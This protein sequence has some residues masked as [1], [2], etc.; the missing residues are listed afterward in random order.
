M[1]FYYF[2]D[3]E[4]IKQCKLNSEIIKKNNKLS[5]YNC[6]CAFDTETTS[7]IS[8]NEKCGTIYLWCFSID[9]IFFIGRTTEQFITFL[10]SV[11]EIFNISSQLKMIIYIHNLAF[12]FQFIKGYFDYSNII[13]N[14]IR[15]PI[16]VETTTGIE[17]RCSYLL[18]GYSLENL[19]KIKLHGI[20]KLKG[21]LNYDLKRNYKTRISKKEY[22]YIYNDVL[23]VSKYIQ[24][25]KSQNENKIFRI[26][27]TKTGYV[28]RFARVETIGTGSRKGF[29]MNNKNYI[30]RKEIKDLI[31]PD[32]NFYLQLK[33]AFQGGYTHC[34]CFNSGKTFKNVSSYD[35]T[36]SYPTML[37]CK[38]FP[39]SSPR[40][41]KDISEKQFN[42]CLEIYNCIFNIKFVNI[43]SKE[44]FEHYISSS[45]CFN[46]T[47]IKAE[48]GRLI[49]ADV[50]EM[51]ITEIDYKIIK[52]MYNFDEMYISN[53]NVFTKGYLPKSFI[54]SVLKLYN[55]KTEL[56]GV[57]GRE[58]EYLNSKEM[59][60]SMYGMCVTDI[61]QDDF[62]VINGEWKIDEKKEK[63][64]IIEKNNNSF[65]R[66]LY[67]PWGIYTTAYA[68][69]ALFTA[70]KTIK[71]DYIYSDTDS[72]KI[73]NSEK[74]KSYFENYNN[75]IITDLEK[76]CDFYDIDKKLIKP[77]NKKGIEKPLGVWDFEGSGEFKALHSKCYLSNFDDKLQLTIAGLNKENGIKYL[78][79]NYSNNVF[80]VFT[81]NL[82]IPKNETGKLTHF[83][84]DNE[85]HTV[86]KDYQ[87]NF[88]KVNEKSSIYLEKSEFNMSIDENYLNYIDEVQF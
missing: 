87:G 71:Y 76:M 23:I 73:L 7:F 4:K 5:Y 79:R 75:Q 3:V 88:A 6:I 85:I 62:K 1:F 56:K 14:K 81:N 86:I 40:E 74:Y 12:E 65:N 49:S 61:I 80:K 50:I 9:S 17:F 28:R 45:K 39:I 38:L 15:K 37:C 41:I 18:S 82:K 48:N 63:E 47:N 10:N 64:N 36:S 68:R 43:Q 77:K 16:A 25:E 35:F 83:Y 44:F 24:L 13:A 52:D 46:Y 26:P 60:N 11:I 42:R 55:D 53:F 20:K 30:Y 34:S 54:Q 57:P 2:N 78:N 19:A 8:N 58:L 21:N 70:I 67:Y 72:V 22:N 33:R 32:Y 51:T 69:E 31:I 27:Y 59:L 66:F 29:K 84:N